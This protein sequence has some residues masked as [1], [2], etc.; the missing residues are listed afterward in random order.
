M[1]VAFLIFSDCESNCVTDVDFNDEV[2]LSAP[3]RFPFLTVTIAESEKK[4]TQA[5]VPQVL[6]KVM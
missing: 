2:Y 4:I 6:S 3:H 1:N 5:L